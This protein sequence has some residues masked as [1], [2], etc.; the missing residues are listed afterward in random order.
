MSNLDLWNKVD[1]IDP[2]F[3]K[4]ITGRDY[5]GTSPNPQYLIKLATE[6]L[7][8]VGKGFGWYVLAENF[9]PLGDTVL[10]WC[11]IRFWWRDE[12]GKEHTVDQY[13]QTKAQYTTRN[14]R[15][16]VDEDAP[17]KSLTDAVVKALSHLGFAANIFL[18]RWDDQKYVAQVREEYRNADLADAPPPVNA[19]KKLKPADDC[20]NQLDGAVSV[21][22]FVHAVANTLR[23]FPEKWP[24]EVTEA[25]ER[26]AEKLDCRLVDVGRRA[27]AINAA[28]GQA[29]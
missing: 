20:I 13:G 19:P 21:E 3:T 17:K 12:G 10:H 26:N 25:A 2:K 15:V 7:G 4:P 5:Q 11:R 9:Q 22:G 14:G 16:L 29:A 23:A 6:H 28:E 24:R 8:P 1:D 27:R 18:G